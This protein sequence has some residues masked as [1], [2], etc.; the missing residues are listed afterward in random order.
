MAGTVWIGKI[1]VR[2]EF[3]KKEENDVWSSWITE[4]MSAE[5]H[6]PKSLSKGNII[7]K[8]TRYFVRTKY[9]STENTYS[10]IKDY[11][12]ESWRPVTKILKGN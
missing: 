1:M 9:I 3:E 6:N 5:S 8:C 10:V 2:N 7:L 11:A 4:F 12:V